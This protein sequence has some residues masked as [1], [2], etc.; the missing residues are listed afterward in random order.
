MRD[1]LNIIN[2]YK[3][4]IG[5]VILGIGSALDVAGMTEI[6]QPLIEAGGVIAGV[7][8]LHKAIK[9]KQG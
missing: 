3:Q 6:G 5:L 8:A 1:P 7:G 9:M 4:I 2:G